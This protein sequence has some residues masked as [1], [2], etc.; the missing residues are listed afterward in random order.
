LQEISA[1]LSSLPFAVPCLA[2][3][4]VQHE[5]V[6]LN[7][8]VVRQWNQGDHLCDGIKLQQRHESAAANLGAKGPSSASRFAAASV[9]EP[10][11]C[12][13]SAP[14]RIETKLQPFKFRGF[15]HSCKLCFSCIAAL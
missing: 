12:P 8:A 5:D 1:D 15:V 7:P 13:R 6:A 4:G 2:V 10:V 3:I 9:F 11:F 14:S